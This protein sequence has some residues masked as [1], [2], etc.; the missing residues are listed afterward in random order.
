MTY[1]RV[2]L[3]VMDS[4]GIGCAS[5]AASFGDA[6]SNTFLS[7][8]GAENFSIPNLARL[9]FYHIEG[10]GGAAL[11]DEPDG[12][13][14]RMAERS[15]GKDTTIGHWEIAGI[16]SK[17][18]LPTYPDGFPAEI[19]DEFE[20]RTGRKAICNKPYS[21]VKVIADYGREHME[22]GA[23]IVYTSA[24]SVFQIAA[25]ESL[26]PVEELYRYCEIAREILV[27]KHSVGRVIAR[28]FEGEY[29]F[30]RTSRRHDFSALPPEKTMLDYL[31]E[32][33]L[34][35]ICVGKISD[36]FA[37]IGVS[38]CIRTSGNDDGMRVTLELA[39]RDF[40]GLCFVNL[41]D[42][43]MNFGHRRDIKGYAD[44][45]MRFDAWL[46]DFMPR[47]REDDLL[48]ITADHG[49]D[50]GFTGTDHTR[51]N[52]PLLVYGK[53]VKPQNLGFRETYADIAETIAENFETES[54]GFGKSF[55]GEIRKG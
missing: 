16:Y 18:P 25:H 34:D 53:G 20:R 55:L 8:S 42:F 38:E 7:V 35:T 37:G 47:M 13:Y 41:V 24:D 23:L 31:R 10:N 26:V 5:D 29:P 2:F 14:A 32:K 43:D 48:I 45:V 54:S 51:E 4:F 33:D 12:A 6:G 49:C 22:T 52:V 21:G 3:I 19:L 40:T 1:K 27:G 39:D 44:A 46:S 36:I 50:P 30:A 17:D 15:N 11:S 28:P 9:G